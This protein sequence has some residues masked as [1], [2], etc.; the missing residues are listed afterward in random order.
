M[1]RRTGF[2]W[3]ERYMWHE[4]GRI[5]GI[6]PVG[7][8]VEPGSPHETTAT[9]RRI[10]NLVDASGFIDH[11][12]AVKPREATRQEL[13]RVH[14]PAYLDRL[15]VLNREAEA[16]AGLDGFM[17]RG[18][19]DIARLAAGGALAAVDA[20]YSGT[21]TNAYA[22]VRPV[23]H[24]AEADQ[25]LGFCL[26]SNAALAAAHAMATHGAR[27]V[28]LVDIDVHHG[29]GAQR[30]FWNDPRVLTIS[31][32]Q[33]CWFPPDC[34]ALD[35]RGGPEAFGTNVNLPLPAGCGWGAYEAA[36][37]TVVM[38]A[39]E[40]FRPDFVIM[41]CGFDAGAQDPLGRMILHG[42]A[43]AAMTEKLLA[44]CERTI[45]GRL[46]LTHEG[47]YNPYTV[48]FMALAVLE[49]LAGRSSGV[50]DPLGQIFAGMKG[51]EL[52]PHQAEVI[53]QAARFL[54]DIPAGGG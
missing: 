48:P 1:D 5:A 30:I 50:T 2:V 18:S 16:V 10:K 39:L 53:A 38:P 52:L 49:V 3:H 31:L 17:T 45:G 4:G 36:F 34:G 41:P 11:L 32:H 15:A 21:V 43:F 9:K 35:E 7:Y 37:D 40:R 33:D 19:Y 23:G 6:V 8:P 51:H 47:G 26:L 24:H 22:L 14:T 12:V 42:G 13:L 28:A 29:N 25:G 46:L 54:A 44:F 20:I 27:R